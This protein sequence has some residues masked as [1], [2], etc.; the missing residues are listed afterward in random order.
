MPI[1]GGTHTIIVVLG[2]WISPAWAANLHAG[3]TWNDPTG[4]AYG[5]RADLTTPSSQP[6]MYDGFIAA[7]Y[8]STAASGGTW[9]QTGWDYVIGNT[10]PS[11]Y[12]EGF[13]DGTRYLHYVGQP[14]PSWDFTRAYEVRWNYGIAPVGLGPLEA[15]V[16]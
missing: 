1:Q 9:A 2:V 11:S 7:G 13:K 4:N 5:V 15:K 14:M 8:V 6:I 12:V 3:R 16:L 10:R